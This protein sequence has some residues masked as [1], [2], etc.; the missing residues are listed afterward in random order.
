VTSVDP[1]LGPLSAP[2]QLV[3][4]ESF[5]CPHCQRFATDLSRLH[6]EF[7]DRLLVV[8]KHYPLSTHCNRLLSADL[9]PGACE[10]AWAAEA[11]NLQSGFWP[12]HDAML[13]A[14]S[15][16]SEESLRATAR[17]LRLDPVRFDRDRRSDSA[18]LRVAGGCRTGESA[19]APGDAR[20]LPER[21]VGAFDQGRGAGAPGAS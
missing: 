15:P 4:F 5:R 12:F 14:E 21:A 19:E 3:V 20:G 16:P 2:V 6:R 7:G 10:I 13:A 9:Q 1:H 17:R 11:A 8:Y 18:R